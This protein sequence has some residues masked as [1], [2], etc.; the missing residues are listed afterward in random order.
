M[1]KRAA[2]PTEPALQKKFLACGNFLS[3]NGKRS[4]KDVRALSAFFS[5]S[6]LERFFFATPLDEG[7][8]GADEEE[9]HT[10][11]RRGGEEI[12]ERKEAESLSEMIFH[13]VTSF[14]LLVALLLLAASLVERVRSSIEMEIC[15]ERP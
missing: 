1:E 10:Q 2:A 12:A 15:G 14:R 9:K 5:C 7:K 13:I 11:N 8:S 4:T 6:F 3:L